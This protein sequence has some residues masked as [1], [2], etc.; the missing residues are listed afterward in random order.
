M[1]NED[2]NLSYKDTHPNLN[3]MISN[4]DK[5]TLILLAFINHFFFF[6]VRPT[7]DALLVRPNNYT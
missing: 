6:H 4:L 5:R 1:T 3:D 2:T 7:Y